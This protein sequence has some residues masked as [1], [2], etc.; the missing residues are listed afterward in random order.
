MNAL[1]DMLSRSRFYGA[2]SEPIDAV[3][4]VRDRTEDEEEEEDE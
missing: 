3:E 4:V 2:K 1:A